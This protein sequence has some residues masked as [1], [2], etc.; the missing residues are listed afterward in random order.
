MKKKVLK[1]DTLFKPSI[2]P[3]SSNLDE[4]YTSETTFRGYYK[5][6]KAFLAASIPEMCRLFITN[7]L[8]PK[9]QSALFTDKNITLE[10]PII[11]TG[12][13][14]SLLFWLKNNL[15]RPTPLFAQ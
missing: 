10:T 6:N 5:T 7:L 4:F 8:D 15:L 9:L 2:L 13:E 3:R 12:A 14:E 1:L 11:S